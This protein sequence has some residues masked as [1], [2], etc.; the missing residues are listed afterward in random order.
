[1]K[2]LP[3]APD[4]AVEVRSS[5][6]TRREVKEKVTDW[7]AAGTRGVW[8]VDPQRRT[9]SVYC[10]ASDATKLSEG[11]ELDGGEVVPGF[12]CRV[13]EIFDEPF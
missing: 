8:V 12:R 3:F 9:V 6:D 2:F 13:A 5:G 11:D 10:S 7:I 4:L 1:M